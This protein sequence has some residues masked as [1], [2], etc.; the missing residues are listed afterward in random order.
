[1]SS[2]EASTTAFFFQIIR[3]GRFLIMACKK[4]VVKGSL[5]KHLAWWKRYANHT[6]AD[7]IENGYRIPFTEFPPQ[8]FSL[9]NLSAKKHSEFVEKTIGELL[10]TGAIVRVHNMPHVVNPL[11]VAENSTKLRLVLDLRWV[12]PYVDLAVMKF[13]DV[14]VASQYFQKNQLISTFDLQSGYHH[15]DMCADQ[16]TLLGFKWDYQGIPSFF[17]YTVLAFGLRS[18]GLAFTKVL[19]VLVKKWRSQGLMV[20]LYI[21]DGIILSNENNAFDNVITIREDL[22]NAGFLVN[23]E[24]TLDAFKTSSLVRFQIEL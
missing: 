9:N 10:E 21:D 4:P 19:R 17:Q 7:I 5:L 1:M 23:E 16:Q 12:N 24:I 6:I 20:V 14:S 13:E 3:L 22:K 2:I 18:A 11:T 15:I 8:S